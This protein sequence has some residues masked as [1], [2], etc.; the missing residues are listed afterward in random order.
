V[1][2]LFRSILR[3]LGATAGI[4]LFIVLAFGLAVRQPGMGKYAFPEGP[5]ADPALFQRHVEYLCAQAFPRNPTAADRL[6][7]AADYIKASLSGTGASVSEQPYEAFRKPFRNIIARFGPVAGPRV[8]VG[9]HYDVY[10]EL[11]GADDNASGVAGLLELARLLAARHL[12]SPVELVAFSTEEPPYFGGPE[13]GSAV[14]ARSLQ[15]AGVR[16]QVMIGLEMIGFF[17]PAQP[18]TTLPLYLVYPRT[19]DFITVA[20]RWADRSLARELKKCFRGATTVPAVSYSGPVGIG[21]DLSDHRNYWAAGYPAIMVTD[22]AFMR[23]RNYHTTQDLPS[24]LDYARLA[25]VVD[26]VLSGVVHLAKA[27]IP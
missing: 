15:A 26:G 4:L 11:P 20:G 22:T 16:V 24:S 27:D 1:R 9:A 14:H 7:L 10:G 5:R 17:S 23:N 21:A 25:G 3:I 13:M 8:V 6:N 12:D 2:G 19:G 18:Y